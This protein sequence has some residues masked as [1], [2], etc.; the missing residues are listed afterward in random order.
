M[1]LHLS[2]HAL[3]V[4]AKEN[5]KDAE[6]TDKDLV[7]VYEEI[8]SVVNKY[9]ELYDINKFRQKLNE[10]LEIF[11]KLPVYNVYESNKIKQVGK[12]EVLNRILMGLHANAMITD[13]KVLGIKT[14]LGQ[15]QV[16]GGIKLSPDAK[17]I[18]QSPTG[19]F[20]RAVR[21][22]DLG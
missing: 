1:Q 10:G 3:E 6:I 17:L 19:I 13:L 7:S 15:M 14:K 20:S 16:N 9:F 4:L 5:V 11:R 2:K 12:F 21:V 8:L 18:Y 22:K